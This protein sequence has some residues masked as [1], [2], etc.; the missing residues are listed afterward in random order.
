VSVTNR[1]SQQRYNFIS[2]E[3]G[4][5]LYS[6]NTS[7]KVL[8]VFYFPVNPYTHLHGQIATKL[9]QSTPLSSA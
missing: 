9:L 5:K 2:T 6:R 4:S 8:L 7:K 3:D 1:N